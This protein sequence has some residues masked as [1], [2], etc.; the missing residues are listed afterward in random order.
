[1]TGAPLAHG[2]ANRTWV[3]QARADAGERGGT[4]TSDAGRIRELEREVR[5]ANEIPPQVRPDSLRGRAC[6]SRNEVANLLER[7]GNPEADLHG[8]GTTIASALIAQAGAVRRFRGAA[9]FARY[10]D[11]API[12][13]GSGQASGHHRLYRGGNRQLNAALYRIAVVQA[14]DDVT[15]RAF[16]AR[17][18]SRGQDQARGPASTQRHLANV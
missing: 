13:C 8:A 7:H 14:R 15:G 18:A 16:M 2:R 9:A 12:P 6:G 5:R 3:R 4:T 1:M 17:K 10:S 11:T